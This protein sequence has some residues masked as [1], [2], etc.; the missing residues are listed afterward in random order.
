[1]LRLAMIFKLAALMLL[2]SIGGD[3]LGDT[4]CRP[5]TMAS[6]MSIGPSSHG[7][8]DECG[9]VCVPDCYCCCQVDQPDEDFTLVPTR[10]AIGRQPSPDSSRLHGVKHAIY[11][12]PLSA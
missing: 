5:R 11:H 6:A 3:L 8:T 7:S 4:V 2:A 10:I 9:D 1:M 12:P